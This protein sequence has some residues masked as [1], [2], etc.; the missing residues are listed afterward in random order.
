[1][2]NKIGV[3]IDIGSSSLKFTSMMIENK[4]PKILRAQ[5]FP[6]PE[7]DK[8][9]PE[10]AH[11]LKAFLRENNWKISKAIAGIT[12]QYLNI[13]YFR[14]PTASLSRIPSVIEMEVSQLEEKMENT[15]CYSYTI[16]K[17]QP[18]S[19]QDGP[20]I[21]MAL[22]HESYLKTIYD[23]FHSISINITGFIPLPM[24]IAE[25]LQHFSLAP[26]SQNVYVV[27]I[28][29]E[30]TSLILSSSEGFSFFRNLHTGIKTLKS[31][32]SN[33]EEQSGIELMYNDEQKDD[34][35]TSRRISNL[36]DA[37]RKFAYIQTG[38]KMF[39]IDDIKMPKIDGIKMPKID[40]VI[41]SGGGSQEPSLKQVLQ[42]DFQSDIDIWTP[43]IDITKMAV[44]DKEHFAKNSVY[45]IASIGLAWIALQPKK[46]WLILNKEQE[47]QKE[48]FSKHIFE[49]SAL[50]LFFI[51]LLFSIPFIKADLHN[52]Q[53][54]HA[55][56]SQKY[57]TLMNRL[58][59]SKQLDEEIEGLQKKYSIVSN[60][61][62]LN[63]K[64]CYAIERLEQNLPPS[65]TL[66]QWNWKQNDTQY[67]LQISGFVTE[68]SE[69]VYQVLQHFKSSIQEENISIKSENSPQT[70]RERKLQFSWE[71]EIK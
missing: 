42:E 4:E 12:G 15:L 30:N 49:Y 46:E 16:P 65:I 2:F 39:K 25:S 27:D 20:L 54:H 21:A 66:T 59:K 31:I 23:F 7:N 62:N 47:Q 37:T 13:R 32:S 60:Y 58:T 36:M 11:R 43:Q 26:S 51:S 52:L 19:K 3:G 44:R 48:L 38:I 56:L 68:T 10:V 69:D 34:Q 24:A 9:T 67:I 14:S 29:A 53:E 70:D 5:I 22:V 18:A 57:D 71:L 35:C 17:N 28:G 41:L 6:L 8:F 1:M 64:L 55:Q 33:D 50:L 45:Y 63:P 61:L 40:K